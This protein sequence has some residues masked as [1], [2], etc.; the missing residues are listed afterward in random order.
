MDLL[1]TPTTTPAAAI[2]PTTNIQTK[3]SIAIAPRGWFVRFTLPQIE[4]NSTK[5]YHPK[6]QFQGIPNLETGVLGV[7]GALPINGAVLASV[8][9]GALLCCLEKTA[10]AGVSFPGHG[11]RLCCVI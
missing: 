9:A 2:A 11:R 10:G 5:A 6:R 1:L 7:P 8:C 4:H 3:V